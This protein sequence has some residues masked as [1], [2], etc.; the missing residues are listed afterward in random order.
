MLFAF[1]AMAS[2][3]IAQQIN[4]AAGMQAVFYAFGGFALLWAAFMGVAFRKNMVSA[5]VVRRESLRERI[6]NL[7]SFYRLPGMAE[8]TIIAVLM[9]CWQCSAMM[10]T[11]SM[12]AQV[13][14]NEA[15]GALALT[16]LFSGIMLS[17]LIYARFASR[18][19]AGRMLGFS[20]LL[21]A[22][23]WVAAML[24]P[25]V[26]P[27]IALIGLSAFMC[28]NN[29]PVDISAACRIAP[30]NTAAGAGTVI[31]GSYIAMFA[32][33]PAIGALADAVGLGR[34]MIATAVPLLALFPFA[35]GLHKKMRA[36]QGVF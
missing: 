4:A 31:L 1:G 15:D 17:R 23:L 28:G 10:Y 25:A 32:F 29:F 33:M 27:K 7:A 6:K 21:G 30:A 8:V 19:S 26:V 14:G 18:F 20:N 34:A 16:V 35:L 36:A 5:M 24:V 9:S 22:A 3:M 13:R 12:V 2:P 11:S